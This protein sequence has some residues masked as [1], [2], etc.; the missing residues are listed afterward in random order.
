[1]NI[2]ELI[3]SG[4][5]S[6]FIQES[7]EYSC[8]I[9]RHTKKEGLDEFLARING[10]E[11]ETQHKLRKKFAISNKFIISELLRPID[12]VWTA[13]GG[14]FDIGATSENIKIDFYTFSSTAWGGRSINDFVKTVWREAFIDDPN[15]LIYISFDQVSGQYYPEFIST[16][17]ILD[18]AVRG[19]S[20][21]YLLFE[22]D[23]VD[24]DTGK[25]YFY[26]LIDPQLISTYRKSGDE[27]T[28]IDFAKNPA[29][30]IPAVVVS[31]L[32]TSEEEHRLSP[33][34]AQI[35]LL[36]SIVRKNSVKEIFEFLH[37]YPKHWAY[38]EVCSEC[39]GQGR[40]DNTNKESAEL[41]VNCPKCNG[42][43]QPGSKTDVSDMSLLRIPEGDQAKLANKP[44]GFESPDVEVWQEMRGELD[45]MFDWIF[46]SHWG[47]TISKGSASETATGRFIDVQPVNNR[48]AKYSDSAEL[49]ENEIYS[50]IQKLNFAN[51]V[52]R[53]RRQY[54]RRY[55]IES[56]D[57]ALKR[58]SEGRLAK[59]PATL[60]DYL[61]DQ[62]YSSE[63]ASD[64]LSYNRRNKLNR[65][66]PFIH[67]SIE[68][69]Q[70]MP[71]P[72]EVK[73]QKAIF[74][75]WLSTIALVE[76]DTRSTIELKELLKNFTDQYKPKPV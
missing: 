34:D 60:L 18:Y 31:N 56:P 32:V 24:T 11:N 50:I 20:L 3:K 35:E 37:G 28:L 45:W 64:E 49:I 10:Y 9:K 19:Q 65:V 8:K 25:E 62:Y 55:I 67:S 44:M 6:H 74:S 47:T 2:E 36:D 43:G 63:F 71:V 14:S 66:E 42:T 21:S 40:V 70:A 4:K 39:G 30:M 23:E 5:P 7:R 54:G 12:S 69:V 48:L 51:T 13:R 68:E 76:I 17:R 29:G 16:S 15:G 53:V 52:T 1:M 41:Y 38:G 33:I 26:K 27:V 46:R 73:I 58:Y 22:P 57:A 61:L 72:D 75:E 59:L